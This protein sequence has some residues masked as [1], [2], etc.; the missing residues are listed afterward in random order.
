MA[1]QLRNGDYFLDARGCFVNGNEIDDIIQRVTTCLTVKRGS[2]ALDPD[3]GSELH[4]LNL[5]TATE[6]VLMSYVA[7]AI[8]RVDEVQLMS[9]KRNNNRDDNALALTITLRLKKTDESINVAM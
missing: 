8:S 1:T 9:V 7:E 3:F 2:F 5:H 4:T 6:D